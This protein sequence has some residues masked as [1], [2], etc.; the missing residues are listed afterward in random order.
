[1]ERGVRRWRQVDAQ[2]EVDN[3][4]RQDAARYLRTYTDD[5]GML[6]VRARLTPEVGAV[7]LKALEAAEDTLYETKTLSDVSAET[8]RRSS[9][10]ATKVVMA[11]GEDGVESEAG[12]K[13]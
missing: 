10:D 1:V 5:E 12:T 3:A 9:R 8:S 2:K 11:H 7:F 13:E 6:V 4:K